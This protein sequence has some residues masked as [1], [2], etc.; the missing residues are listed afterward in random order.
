M[1]L[2]PIDPVRAHMRLNATRPALPGIQQKPASSSIAKWCSDLF[3][4]GRCS[5]P[6]AQLTQFRSYRQPSMA[7]SAQLSDGKVMTEGSHAGQDIAHQLNRLPRLGQ[8]LAG[9]G[10]L[11]DKTADPLAKVGWR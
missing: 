11:L 1:P 10:H 8:Q 3:Q 2:V 9:V 6:P 5:R 4:R 7:F